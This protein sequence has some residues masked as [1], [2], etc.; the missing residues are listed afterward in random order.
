MR[1]Q[2]QFLWHL[3]AM[4]SAGMICV[5]RKIGVERTP[6]GLFELIWN[7]GAGHGLILLRLSRNMLD[8]LKACAT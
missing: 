5:A 1:Q 7:L 8:V 4:M 2:H 3:V 6:G